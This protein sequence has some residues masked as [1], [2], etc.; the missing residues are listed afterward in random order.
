VKWLSVALLAVACV[1]LLSLGRVLQTHGAARARWDDST[2]V[3]KDATKRANEATRA[4]EKGTQVEKKYVAHLKRQMAGLQERAKPLPEL[5]RMAVPDTCK[6]VVTMLVEQVA[7][8][9]SV[10]ELKDSTVASYDRQLVYAYQKN[11]AAV[12]Q[13][14]ELEHRLKKPKKPFYVPKLGV[15]AAVGID[16]MGRPNVVA[17]LTVGWSF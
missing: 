17:G 10:I 13:I 12:V 1:A 14:A 16:V 6:P 11:V 2:A 3:L 9:D 8:R 15:G 7:L 4:A 5:Q